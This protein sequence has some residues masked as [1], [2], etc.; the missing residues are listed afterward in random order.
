[1]S[2]E[3]TTTPKPRRRWLQFSLR[4]ALVL[5][6]VLG[7]GFGWLGR[8]VQQART[9]DQAATAIAEGDGIVYYRPASGTEGSPPYF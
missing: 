7:A 2:T 5:M 4:T 6:L 1:M 3:R 9:Q 8:Q